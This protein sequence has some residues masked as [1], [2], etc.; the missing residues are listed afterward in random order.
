MAQSVKGPNFDLSSGHDLAVHEI[1]SCTRLSTGS[2]EPAW[3]SL[4]PSLS[5]PPLLTCARALALSQNKHFFLSFKKIAAPTQEY[6]PF[7]KLKSP[8]KI[9]VSRSAHLRSDSTSRGEVAHR[10]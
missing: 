3:D 8:H 4:S 9:E 2:T 7:S 5:T 10:F 6:Y 1:E